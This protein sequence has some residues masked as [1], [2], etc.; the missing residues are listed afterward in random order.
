MPDKGLIFLAI[1]AIATLGAS[2]GIAALMVANLEQSTTSSI[3]GSL[4]DAGQ[5]W[6]EVDADGL[7]ILLSG[8]APSESDRFRALEIAGQFADVRRID[9]AIDIA[10]QQVQATPEFAV[11]ILR[12][13]HDLALIGLMPRHDDRIALL[14]DMADIHEDGQF[15]DL[16]EAVEFEPP[17]GWVPALEFARDVVERL[18][19]ANVS[20]EPGSVRILAH[21]D[22][23]DDAEDVRKTLTRMTPEGVALD[24]EIS[25]PKPVRSPFVFE[26]A[27]DTERTVAITRCDIT[28]QEALD[29]LSERVEDVGGCTIALGAPTS[30]WIEAVNAGITALKAVPGATLSITDADFAFRGPQDFDPETFEATVASLQSDVPDVF[31]ISAEL[32]PPS[33]TGTSDQAEVL[34]EF[35]AVLDPDAGLEISGPLA[36]ETAA[37]AVRNYAAALFG[38]EAVSAAL[39]TGASVETGWNAKVLSGLEALSHLHQGRVV[40]R[41]DRADVQGISIEETAEEQ[42]RTALLVAFEPADIDVGVTFDAELKRVEAAPDA[43]VCEKQLAGIMRDNNIVFAPNSADISNESE[44]LLD[45]IASIIMSCARAK[46]EIGGHTDSQ[47]REEMNLGLSQSRADAVLDALLARDVLLDH[48]VAKGYGET[49]P[50]ATNETEEGRA[51]NRRIAFKLVVEETEE[52]EAASAGTDNTESSSDGQN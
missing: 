11:D 17:E 31:S 26:A 19:R 21:L 44:L 47:G 27:S 8:T 39:E 14:N 33:D 43:R 52:D 5:S 10:S 9:D 49:E 36:D 23:D 7:K 15:T 42:A 20:V 51:R 37:A 34:T 32:P 18:E 2:W 48:M 1:T 50:I 45:K 22:E 12:N 16:L 4:Q 29:R 28:D 13:G 25:E 38:F 3:S 46:F 35:T 24:L 6:A 30:L 41:D 40:V